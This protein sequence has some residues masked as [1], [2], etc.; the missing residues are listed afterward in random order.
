[1]KKQGVPVKLKSV[2]FVCIYL[3]VHTSYQVKYSSMHSCIGM[4]IY[5]YIQR[6]GYVNTNPTN[7]VIEE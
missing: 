5:I 7:Q 1:M 3:F 2:K 6:T 4:Y